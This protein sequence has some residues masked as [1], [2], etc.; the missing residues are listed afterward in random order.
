MARWRE[1]AVLG[2]AALLLSCATN[3]IT[4]VSP[5]PDPW[6]LDTLVASALRNGTALE[7]QS[8]AAF[9]SASAPPTPWQAGF[10]L[11]TNP[12]RILRPLALLMRMRVKNALITQRLEVLWAARTRIRDA[13][14]DYCEAR[15]LAR[16]KPMG[17]ITTELRLAELGGVSFVPLSELQSGVVLCTDFTALPP[18]VDDQTLLRAAL[19]HRTDY[20]TAIE[21]YLF[22]K[23][24]WH[25]RRG[26]PPLPTGA[27]VPI[28]YRLDTAAEQPAPATLEVALRHRLVVNEVRDYGGDYRTAY[29]QAATTITVGLDLARIKA[30]YKAQRALTPLEN[31][32]RSVS[33]PAGGLTRPW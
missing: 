18:P 3:S 2:L 28:A 5:A 20:L 24:M 22:E 30:W 1:W 15:E 7:A 33:D 17:E 6:A 13:L 32:T 25:R 11:P 9:A 29:R 23:S 26:A 19:T 31:A 12:D 8:D 21:N 16:F 10:T 4:A 27:T 14:I